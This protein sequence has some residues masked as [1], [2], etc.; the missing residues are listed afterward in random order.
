MNEIEEQKKKK[1]IYKVR[2]IN[3]GKTKLLNDNDE[4]DIKIRNQD[5]IKIE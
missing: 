4:N 3:I 1:Q 2:K 5:G